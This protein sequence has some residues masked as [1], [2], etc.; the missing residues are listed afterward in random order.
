MSFNNAKTLFHYIHFINS[1]RFL[2]LFVIRQ[3]SSRFNIV[4]GKTYR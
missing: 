4:I 3:Q 1:V 2:F